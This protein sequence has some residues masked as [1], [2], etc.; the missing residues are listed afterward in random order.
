MAEQVPKLDPEEMRAYKAR[1]W[2]ALERANQAHWASLPAPAKLRIAED[3]LRWGLERSTPAPD[4]RAR[5]LEG[6]RRLS[7]LML[8]GSGGLP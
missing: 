8:R 4:E 7:D 5:D 1:G 6:H 3:L 2:Q